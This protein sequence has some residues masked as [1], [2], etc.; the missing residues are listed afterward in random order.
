M[1]DAKTT[2]TTDLQ[3]TE[4]DEL[5]AHEVENAEP[6]PSQAHLDAIKAGTLKRERDVKASG[7]GKAD[8]QTR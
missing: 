3:P 5:T 2:K 7:T 6:Y 1:A 8:Y 4:T